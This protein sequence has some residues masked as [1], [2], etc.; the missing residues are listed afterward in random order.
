MP[1]TRAF[2]LYQGNW[3]SVDLDWYACSVAVTHVP[4]ER[5]VVVGQKGEVHVGGGGVSAA[6]VPIGGG[7]KGGFRGSLYEVRGIANGKVYAVGTFRQV[8]RRDAPNV[9]PP[10]TPGPDSPRP[11]SP[12]SPSNRST[13]S[14]SRTFTR[15]GGKVK[16]AASTVLQSGTP[17]TRRP[18]SRCTRS[19]ARATALSMPPARKGLYSA[20]AAMPGR[21]SPTT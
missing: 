8:W 2:Q 18:I 16:S 6:E 1:H 17:S 11:R 13:A 15:S 9:W 3:G 19:S 7:K 14:A 4:E 21:L 12:T 10:S 20:D 5:C